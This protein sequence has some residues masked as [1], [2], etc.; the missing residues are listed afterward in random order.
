MKIVSWNVNSLRARFERVK[1]FLDTNKDINILLLQETKCQDKNFPEFD[2]RIL[3]YD[4]AHYGLGQFNGVAVIAKSDLQEV[5]SGFD[6]DQDPYVNDGRIISCLIDGITYISVYC[7]NGR[8]IDSEHYEM[9]LN[10][11]ELLYSHLKELLKTTDEIVIM[12]DFNIAPRDEDVYDIEKFVST[13]HTTKREREALE[14]IIGLGFID[15]YRELYPDVEGFTYWDYRN[16]DFNNNRGLR[17]DLA[18]VSESLKPRIRNFTIS[19][20]SR[21]GDSPSDHAAII[22]E[23]T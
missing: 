17:I 12:G 5:N 7:P 6:N 3:G 10:W 18:L 14:N 23:L 11:F 8:D 1:E 19:R 2:I 21:I 20:E 13:T 4:V 22:L 9:K 15:A 16:G